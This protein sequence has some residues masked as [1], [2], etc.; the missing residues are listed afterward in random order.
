MIGAICDLCIQ[1]T[2]AVGRCIEC[3][4]DEQNLCMQHAVLHHKSIDTCLHEPLL[5]ID[6]MYLEVVEPEMD[7][8]DE[9]ENEMF[10]EEM[11][12]R[13]KAEEKAKESI[14]KYIVENFGYKLEKGEKA[15]KT[16]Q[17]Y[18][19]PHMIGGDIWLTKKTQ[20]PLPKTFEVDGYLFVTQNI[21]FTSDI[22][23]RLEKFGNFKVKIFKQEKDTFC[24]VS[25][26]N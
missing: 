20:K 17:E 2:K 23:K 22:S 4:E 5:N 19:L 3:E 8:K 16:V 12:E 14:I 9:K 24:I 21:V 11:E 6:E 18:V 7:E 26:H 15:L 25:I 10:E 1:P 13:Q